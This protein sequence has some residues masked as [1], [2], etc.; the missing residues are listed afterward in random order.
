MSLSRALFPKLS[1]RARGE[2]MYL[3]LT[4]ALPTSERAESRG[5]VGW[6]R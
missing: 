3:H 5:H 6:T 2:E 1:P 4:E